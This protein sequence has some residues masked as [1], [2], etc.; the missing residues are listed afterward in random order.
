M[1]MVQALTELHRQIHESNVVVNYC[2]NNA[3][4]YHNTQLSTT[5]SSSAVKKKTKQNSENV[6]TNKSLQIRHLYI[7]L[8]FPPIIS[9]YN[10]S[11]YKSSILHLFLN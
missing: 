3:K 10:G 6:A 5:S 2:T 4:T 1:K 11:I 7:I 9:K 8:V